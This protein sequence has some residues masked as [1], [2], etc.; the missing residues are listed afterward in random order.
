MSK[1][2]VTVL[3]AIRTDNSLA[4]ARSEDVSV[5]MH[6][7]QAAEKTLAAEPTSVLLLS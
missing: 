5:I 2:K 4:L 3:P 1:V 7:G 6:Q